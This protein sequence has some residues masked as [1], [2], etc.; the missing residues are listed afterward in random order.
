MDNAISEN[1][2]KLIIFTPG[3]NINHGN[4]L[5]DRMLA[6]ASRDKFPLYVQTWKDDF[7]GPDNKY[8]LNECIRKLHSFDGA[9]L[10]L[11]P[12]LRPSGNRRKDT[13]D[14]LAR[15]A[16]S[17]L[18]VPEEVA[19][20]VL[21][22]IGAVMARF[23]RNRVFLLE[24]ESKA[25]EVPSYFAE[26]N[27]KFH[28]Y[29][30]TAQNIEDGM[31]ESAEYV[32]KEIRELGDTAYFSDLPSFGLA[33]GNFN[34]FIKPVIRSIKE[35][36]EVRIDGNIAK[37]NDVVFVIAYDKERVRAQKDAYPVLDRLGLAKGQITQKNGRVVTFRTL[38][39][40]APS[41]VL[42]IVDIPT[43]LLPAEYAVNKIDELWAGGVSATVD[44]R[45]ILV[46]KEIENYFRYMSILAG[47]EKLPENKIRQIPLDDLESLTLDMIE[48]AAR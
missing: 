26:N 31:A 23:G 16:R 8:A 24:P 7:F 28:T 46:K 12:Q 21:I 40:S 22:E 17:L 29:D 5:R 34:A 45:Q 1:A 38:P 43:N 18:R 25:V 48:T 37:F 39:V 33:H 30:D 14:K 27:A 4:A 35:G 3:T 44:Y 42:V 32:I 6:I 2:I 20:N 11:G 10:I 47:E 15:L 19:P 36:D 41:D 13:I 9:I